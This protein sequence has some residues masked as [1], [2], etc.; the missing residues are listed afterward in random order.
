MQRNTL[1]L[2]VSLLVGLVSCDGK[3]VIEDTGAE[4]AAG[5]E[6]GIPSYDW[7]SDTSTPDLTATDSDGDGTPDAYD[8]DPDDAEIHP[9]AEEVAYDGV[10]NDCDESTRDDDLDGDG[11]GV[12][13]DCDDLDPTVYGDDCDEG[14]EPGEHIDRS[15]GIGDD[16]GGSVGEGSEDDESDLDDDADLD[17]KN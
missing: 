9:G 8:C 6:T 3:G 7:A 2:A 12:D 11:Y 5:N 1:T 14:F 17:H 4:F 16:V 15:A 13:D 10:D